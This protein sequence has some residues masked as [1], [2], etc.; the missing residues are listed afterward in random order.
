[1]QRRFF[2]LTL[3]NIAA[4][5]TVPLVGLVDTAMLGH[6]PQLGPLAGAALAAVLFDY[7]FWSLNFLRLSTTGLVAQA[8]GRGDGREEGH[9]L[10]RA[11]LLAVALGGGVLLLQEPLRRLGF[12]ALGVDPELLSHASAYYGARIWSAPAGLANF[13]LLGYFLGREESGRALAVT[14]IANLANVALNYL[15]IVRLGWE[16]QGA[17]AATAVSQYL[18]LALGLALLPRGWWRPLLRQT[19]RA[20][21][22]AAPQLLELFRLNRDIA[23]RT[24]SMTTALGAFT[25]ISSQL[26]TETLV[27]NTI[28]MRLFLFAAYFIDG[29]A[30]AVESLAGRLFGAGNGEAL[31]RLLHLAMATGIALAVTFLAILHLFPQGIY[32][33]LTSHGAIIAEARHFGLWLIPVLLLGAAA[34][35]YDGLFLGLTRGRTLRNAMVLCAFGVFLPVAAAALIRGENHLLWAAMGAWMASRAGI[36]A[37]AAR[38]TVQGLG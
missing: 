31:R 24:L 30:F 38:R 27:V 36:L 25:A 20:V 29:A 12:F 33:L 3:L 11:L 7:L 1:L 32:G 5:L 9:I 17:G 28:L 14:A 16:A 13:A 4:N 8:A 10:G 18:M 19:G 6:L 35:I 23:I 26:G 37:V 21:W 2:R 15:F 22:L 34:F